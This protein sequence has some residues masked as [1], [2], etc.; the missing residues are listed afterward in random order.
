VQAHRISETADSGEYAEKMSEI[1][2][3]FLRGLMS[4]DTIIRYEKK[5]GDFKKIMNLE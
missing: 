2:F 1:S 3:T 5:E 4:T